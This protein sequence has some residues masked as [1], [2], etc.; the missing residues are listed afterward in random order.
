MPNQSTTTAPDGALEAARLVNDVLRA[1]QAGEPNEDIAPK[2][3]HAG[4]MFALETI[5]PT[6]AIEGLLA[7][8]QQLASEFPSEFALIKLVHTDAVPSASWPQA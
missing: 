7:L 5:G 3:I 6:R 4:L 2:L 8:T 1:W